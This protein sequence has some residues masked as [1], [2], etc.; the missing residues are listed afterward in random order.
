MKIIIAKAQVATWRR[1][2]GNG[3]L[4]EDSGFWLLH[5][6]QTDH[7]PGHIILVVINALSYSLLLLTGQK[8][9]LPGSIAQL[10]TLA[11]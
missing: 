1:A 6:G 8:R 5:S 7:N 9:P 4:M 2:D 11:R 3:F 10:R